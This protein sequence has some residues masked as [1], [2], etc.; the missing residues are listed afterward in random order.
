M[1]PI[2]L[3]RLDHRSDYI[4]G[5]GEGDAAQGTDQLITGPY[6]EVAPMIFPAVVCQPGDRDSP[7]LVEVDRRT[8]RWLA[9]PIPGLSRPVRGHDG[10][11]GGNSRL[12]H[13]LSSLVLV[14]WPQL[15]NG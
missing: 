11:A 14:S 8:H 6:L 15:L 5:V 4:L 9:H 13:L 1:S 3:A 7:G 12:A 2:D 10:G